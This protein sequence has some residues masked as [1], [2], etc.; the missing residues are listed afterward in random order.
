VPCGPLLDAAD[1]ARIETKVVSIEHLLHRLADRRLFLR[2][3]RAA[4]TRVPNLAPSRGTIKNP[5]PA[6]LMRDAKQG[7]DT[8]RVVRLLIGCKLD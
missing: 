1:S 7:L 8:K 2:S 3:R 5:A 6:R 4:A